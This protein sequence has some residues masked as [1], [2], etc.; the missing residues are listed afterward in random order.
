MTHKTEE[1]KRKHREYMARW[2]MLHPGYRREQ[3]LKNREKILAKKSAQRAAD[4]QKDRDYQNGRRRG[5]KKDEIRAREKLYERRHSEQYRLNARRWRERNKE[6]LAALVHARQ[7]MDPVEAARFLALRKSCDIC[8]R[9]G[10]VL[11]PDHDHV[12]GHI[13]GVLCRGCNSA[14]GILGDTLES[15]RKAVTYLEIS[16]PRG[17]PSQC[18]AS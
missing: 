2:I 1:Q 16:E 4:P 17:E 15:L 6:K 10:C 13:R 18:W 11:V 5:P 14:L 3:Y 12:R 8:G 7:G 9:T